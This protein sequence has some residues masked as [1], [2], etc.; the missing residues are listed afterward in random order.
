[1][2]TLLFSSSWY[3]V[4]QLKPRLRTHARLVRHIYRGE[5]WYVLQDL[6]S[7]RFLRFNPTAYRIIALM[8]GVRTLEDIWRL[9]CERLGDAV[10]TQDEVLHL[11]SQLHQANVLLTD[12]RPDLE[13]LNQRRARGKQQK[14]KQYLANPLSLKLPLGDPDR[15]LTRLATWLP[16]RSGAVLLLAVWGLLVASGATMAVLHWQALTEDLAARVFT[17]DNALVLWLVFPLLKLIH[18]LSH[19]LALKWLGRSCHE[20]GLMF[21]VLVPVPYV[22]ATEVTALPNKWQRMLVGVA[23]MMSELAVASLAMWWWTAAGEGLVKAALHQVVIM[24]GLTTLIFNANPLLRFD[25]YYVFSD[26]LEIPNLGQK[27]NRYL[28]YLI[29]HRL[30]GVEGLSPMPLTPREAPWLI[31]YAIGAFVYRI[32]VTVGIIFLVAEQYFFIGVLLGLWSF[33]GMVPQPLMRQLRYLAA[34]PVLDGRRRRAWL[35]A[36][37]PVVAGLGLLL[38]VPAPSR[39]LTE[40]VIWM[41]EQSQVRAP[42]PCFGRSILVSPGRVV[43]KGDALVECN[44][45][46]LDA[47][48]AELEGHARELQSRLNLAVGNGDQ[49]QAQIIRADI[50]HQADAM[51]DIEQRRAQLRI[52]SPHAGNYVMPAPA[53]FPGRYLERGQLIGYVLDPALFTLITVVPQGQVDLVRNRT[54]RVELRSIDRIDEMLSAR[55]IR[56]VPAAS[57]ELPSLALSLQGGGGI[58]LDPRNDSGNAPRALVSL[59]QFELEF[60]GAER[61]KTLGSRVYVRFVHEPEPLAQQWY[62]LIRQEFLRRFAV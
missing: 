30:F 50:A 19:G 22:D 6:A 49:I 59:F 24:A 37:A 26:W 34:S 54:V 44:D 32:L 11:L 40:G 62:R 2:T 35:V 27:A 5:R 36:T 13:E 52:P 17:P 21:L 8:D 56:E 39:T 23:G 45:P 42:L 4:A 51:R 29:N 38:L 53:D 7:G 9:A 15:W 16:Q 47:R 12:R 3:R 1:M 57:R 14:L 58:G 43:G 10:P 61:P 28:A 60:E 48:H 31:V 55:I 33:Y 41:P 20:F 46:E 25:G 18:E